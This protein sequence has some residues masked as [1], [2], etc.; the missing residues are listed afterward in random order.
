MRKRVHQV[1]SRGCVRIYSCSRDEHV[2][3]TARQ[4]GAAQIGSSPQTPHVDMLAACIDPENHLLPV[5]V[6]ASTCQR[7]FS[8]AA[9]LTAMCSD[10]TSPLS[11]TYW[12]GLAFPAKPAATTTTPV[13]L[14][15]LANHQLDTGRF[16]LSHE[17]HTATAAVAAQLGTHSCVAG[18]PEHW[19]YLHYPL[20]MSACSQ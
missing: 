1:S 8:T 5:Q 14:K 6:P 3:A 19:V 9:A 15:S 18:N 17:H 4:T 12:A 20:C 7:T 2:T 13:S 16:I 11:P 10:T